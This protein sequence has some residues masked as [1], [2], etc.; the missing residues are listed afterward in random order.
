MRDRLTIAYVV[1]ACRLDKTR[2]V[3]APEDEL[4]IS[5]DPLDI[6]N[7]VSE[8]FVFNPNCTLILLLYTLNPITVGTTDNVQVDEVTCA[9]FVDPPTF[10]LPAC[11]P[12]AVFVDNLNITNV[13]STPDT[14][15]IEDKLTPKWLP[16]PV[17]TTICVPAGFPF[18]PKVTLTLVV[19]TWNPVTV[20]ALA[21]VA[22]EVTVVTDDASIL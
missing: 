5:N 10:R 22:V 8:G 6:S 15:P 16:V 12:Y 17:D 4:L 18:A 3:S 9:A 14:F 21:R 1:F 19:Y 7:T 11:N 20:I 2:V 13:V